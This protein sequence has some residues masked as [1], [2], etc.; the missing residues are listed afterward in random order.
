MC[1]ITI[2][3]A[4]LFS[5]HSKKAVKDPVTANMKRRSLK[6]KGLHQ[7]KQ[8][9]IMSDVLLGPLLFIAGVFFLFLWITSQM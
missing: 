4:S 8:L 5:C 9:L 2:W 3:I 7:I 1:A 6:K